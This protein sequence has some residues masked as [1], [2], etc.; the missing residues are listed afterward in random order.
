MEEKDLNNT[1]TDDVFGA[2][3]G[4]DVDLDLPDTEEQDAHIEDGINVVDED[5]YPH[6]RINSRDFLNALNTCST[7]LEKMS[8][9]TIY[10]SIV[11][12]VQGKDCYFKAISPVAFLH[13][14]CG[15][16]NTKDDLILN[17]KICIQHDLL[18]K[19]CKVLAKDILIIKK[20]DGIYL[21]LIGGDLKIPTEE[22]KSIERFE[23]PKGDTTE[24][25][26]VDSHSFG[27]KLVGFESLVNAA[28]KTSDKRILLH[29]DGIYFNDISIWVK[30]LFSGITSDLVL[31]SVDIKVLRKLIDLSESATMTFNKVNNSTFNYVLVKN[32]NSTF[33]FIADSNPFST[34]F[35]DEADLSLVAT[36]GVKVNATHLKNYANLGIVLPNASEWLHL[37]P[38]DD[39][40]ICGV[41]QKVTGLSKFS[42]ELLSENRLEKLKEL[43]KV[44]SRKFYSL[45]SALNCVGEVKLYMSDDKS[46]V[47][48]FNDV[49]N[50]YGL[51]QKV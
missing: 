27:E 1:T 35:L 50:T 25:L 2:F 20:D 28:I 19:V 42:L 7:V 17:E 47:Y 41:E 49:T 15:I 37:L 9:D 34:E 21:R 33:V 32:S 18:M 22:F 12:E 14:H 10:K 38:N 6:I 43:P 23:L 24:F 11:I 39:K 16:T 26:T 51:I 30:T 13:F 46:F 48:V 36:K 44:N 8:T 40:L 29:G 31:R 5:T 3:D 4:A 45:L